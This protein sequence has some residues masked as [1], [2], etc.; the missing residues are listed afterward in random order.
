MLNAHAAVV[1]LYRTQY[2]FR[3]RGLIGIVLNHDWGEPL[4]QSAADI[5]AA[6][7]RNEFAMGWFFDPIVF[8]SYPK[9]MRELVGE[10][11]PKFTKIQQ[12]LLAGSFDFIGLNHYS[13]KYISNNSSYNGK[14]G[15]GWPDD[16]VLTPYILDQSSSRFIP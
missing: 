10:R 5:A 1:A 7:R 6:E 14:G 11:L 15:G 9:S 4:T 13:A 2:Q 3:Q 8:G 12:T 16:Q